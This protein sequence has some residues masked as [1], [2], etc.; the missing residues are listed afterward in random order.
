MEANVTAAISGFLGAVLG[1]AIST[2]VNWYISRRQLTAQFRLA[3]LDRRL[4]THQEA[5]VLWRQLLSTVN[6]GEKISEVVRKCEDWWIENCLYL[7]AGSREAFWTACKLAADF[8]QLDYDSELRERH[9]AKIEQVGTLI[10]EGAHLPAI[11]EEAKI[12]DRR[13]VRGG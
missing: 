1:A 7:D 10:A 6:D 4:A 9:F 2:T 5:Y 12:V 3:A 11:A 8:H 13:Q